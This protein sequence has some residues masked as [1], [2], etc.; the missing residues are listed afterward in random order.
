M[1]A[2]KRLHQAAA[3]AAAAERVAVAAGTSASHYPRMLSPLALKNG[4][5][6]KNRVIMGSMHTVKPKDRQSPALPISVVC[7]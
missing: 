7:P 6:L 5:T 3:A 1:Q 4:T 2:S